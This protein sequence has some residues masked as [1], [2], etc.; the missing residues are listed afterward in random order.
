MR[1]YPPDSSATFNG[2]FHSDYKAAWE[3][4]VLRL[5]EHCLYFKKSLRVYYIPYTGIKRCFRRVMLVPAKLCCGKGDFE[6][7]NL[8]ICNA[9]EE[10]AQIQL[11]GN[12]A[13]KIVIDRLKHLLPPGVDFSAPRTPSSAGGKS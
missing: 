6:V 3:V 4:G 9:S 7:E 2:D 11:P 5:G 1:F 12:K 8:V 13:A 10:L